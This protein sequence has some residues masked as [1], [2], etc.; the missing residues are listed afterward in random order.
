MAGFDW[1]NLGTQLSQPGANFGTQSPQEQGA[2]QPNYLDRLIAAMGQ[3]AAQ[4]AGAAMS[5]SDQQ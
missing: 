4:A 5:N 1:A 3:G 2:P